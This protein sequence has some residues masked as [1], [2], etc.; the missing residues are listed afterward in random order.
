VLR[1]LHAAAIAGAPWQSG[2]AALAASGSHSLKLGDLF[3][4][5][6]EAN[7]RGYY[8]FSPALLQQRAA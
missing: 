6:R 5:K 2:K 3:K 8:R 7:G 4:R 1:F